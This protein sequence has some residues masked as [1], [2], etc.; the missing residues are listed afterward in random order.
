MRPRAD[1]DQ[2]DRVRQ[3]SG[4]PFEAAADPLTSRGGL[5]SPAVVTTI[6]IALLT[7][8]YAVLGLAVL[9]PDTVYSGDIGVKF[10]QA[11]ALA[12]SRFTS[13]D[14]PYP[15]QFLD[16]GREM[17]PI[18]PPFVMTT[19]GSTQAIFSPTSAAV[20]AVYAAISRSRNGRCRAYS[21]APRERTAIRCRGCRS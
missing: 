2:P 18:R 8:V 4:E 19:G 10:V 14:I 12:A 13:L 9:E 17:F 15:G 3:R 1:D 7:A 21:S 5:S 6:A 11:R 16:P 20:I